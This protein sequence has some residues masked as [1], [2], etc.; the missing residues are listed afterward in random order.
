MKVDYSLRAREDR[1]ESDGF[2]TFVTLRE[3]AVPAGLESHFAPSSDLPRD[4]NNRN[5]SLPRVLTR[6]RTP[7]QGT[8]FC[9][10]L[11]KVTKVM[12][13]DKSDDSAR[14]GRLLSLLL[15]S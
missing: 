6:P 13:S 11:T 12:N 5:S 1:R 15:F 3:S 7:Y 10:I 14:F 9:P 2:A 8:V 4:Q